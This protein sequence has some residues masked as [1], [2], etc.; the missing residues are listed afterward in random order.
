[1]A[2]NTTFCGP[3]SERHI[4]KPSANWCTECE[5]AICDDCKEHHKVFKA[6]R[7]HELIPI[8]KYKSLPSFITDIQQSCTNHKEKYQQYCV[9]HALPICLKCIK[10]HQKCNGIPLEEVTNN[11]TTSGHFQDLETRLIDLLQNIDRIK[12]NRKANLK[13]IEEMKELHLAEIQQIRHQINKNLDILEKEIKQ[14]LEKK[15]C[16]CKTNIQQ[17]LSSVKEKKNLI[18][19]YQTTL[20]GIKQHGSNLQLFLVMKDIEVKVLENEQF[21]QSLIERKQIEQWVL[22]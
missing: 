2:T 8:D 13:S 4:T 6:T 19:E 21:L 17:M 3:C 1:M 5:E 11:A 10:E 20:Q 18:T 22:K 9:G 14:D 12:K 16:Q 15:E 7:G